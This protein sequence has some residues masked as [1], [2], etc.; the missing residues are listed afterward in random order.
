MQQL[1][2]KCGQAVHFHVTC[3]IYLA[4]KIASLLQCEDVC[5][6]Y[7]SCNFLLVGCWWKAVGGCWQLSWFCLLLSSSVLSLGCDLAMG[8]ITRWGKPS[9]PSICD[10][11]CQLNWSVCF[12]SILPVC[13]CLVTAWLWTLKPASAE[14]AAI[15]IN[16]IFCPKAPSQN[17][18]SIHQTSAK[19]FLIWQV[20][21]LA[22]IQVVISIKLSMC[23]S[24]KIQFQRIW[25]FLG[26]AKILL[27]G[28][29]ARAAGA[30]IKLAA[31]C[32]SP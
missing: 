10:F 19:Q 22:I 8:Q 31:Q 14:L 17:I 5:K 29:A 2:L 27:H 23:F 9:C 26:L 11:A 12:P 20:V 24:V 18:F 32:H 6:H 21:I 13:F 25:D 4:I 28:R 7:N 30:A 3:T 16:S 15:Q 1:P